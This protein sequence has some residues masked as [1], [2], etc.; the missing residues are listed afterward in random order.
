MGSFKAFA[1]QILS[2]TRLEI[3]GGIIEIA[4][5]EYIM[6]N[7]AQLSDFE[8]GARRLFEEWQSG[9]GSF[10]AETDFFIKH[11]AHLFFLWLTE[12]FPF[13]VENLNIDVGAHSAVDSQYKIHYNYQIDEMIVMRTAL[14]KNQIYGEEAIRDVATFLLTNAVKS[15]SKTFSSIIN[16]DY[17]IFTASLDCVIDVFSIAVDY[18]AAGRIRK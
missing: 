13:N 4:F 9:G 1:E 15:I 7:Q 18:E 8:A 12:V 10:L 17:K 2:Q 11:G 6:N 3:A 16:M 5:L 14:K